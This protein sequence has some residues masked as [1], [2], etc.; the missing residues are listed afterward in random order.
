MRRANPPGTRVGVVMTGRPSASAMVVDCGEK[1]MTVRHRISIL[2]C[3]FAAASALGGS[4]V[5][6]APSPGIIQFQSPTRNIACSMSAENVVCMVAQRIYTA[7]P[8]P[9]DCHGGW[10]DEFAL[11]AGQPVQIVCH[12]DRPVGNDVPELPYGDQ[13]QLGNILCSSMVGYLVCTDL[14][15]GHG[16]HLAREFYT[17]Y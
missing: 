4:V 1:T 7:P 17:I 12:T 3:V 11:P 6:A 10:G 15:T 9:P 16:F 5:A 14:G 8:P 2:V 13:R